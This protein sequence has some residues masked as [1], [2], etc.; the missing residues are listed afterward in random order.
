MKSFRSYQLARSLYRDIVSIELPR[1]LGD[2]LR[3]AAA[4]CAL[5]LAEGYGRVSLADQRR[6]FVMTLG[7]IREVQAIFDLACDRFTDTQRDQ[8]DHLAASVW[9]LVHRPR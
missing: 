1:P 8:L 3:R 4:S 9:R 5:T 6:F 7:S 2:Q